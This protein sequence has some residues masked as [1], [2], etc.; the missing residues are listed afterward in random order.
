MLC[1]QRTPARTT[2][3]AMVSRCYV[4]AQFACIAV[5]AFPFGAWPNH[6][7]GLPL[8]IVGA[9]VGIWALSANR[10]GN[11]HI[12]PDPR[13]DGHLVTSGPYRFIRHPMYFAVLAFCAGLAAAYGQWWRGIPFI[14]LLLVLHFKA[15]FEER[16]LE[17]RYPEY[18]AYARRTRRLI[19]GV[20]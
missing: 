3:T 9:G 11:F 14:A 13:T 2:V 8:S 20:I 18:A 6:W 10:P 7:I 4:I 19:P 5:L 16:A 15:R 12:R 17:A 1:R